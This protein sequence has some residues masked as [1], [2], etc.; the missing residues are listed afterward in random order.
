MHFSSPLVASRA[1]FKSKRALEA[2]VGA[3]DFEKPDCRVL[4]SFDPA[5]C[6][7]G[8]AQ[9]NPIPTVDRTVFEP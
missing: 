3:M 8:A 6:R 1:A 7:R 9:R 2:V 5:F 4:D